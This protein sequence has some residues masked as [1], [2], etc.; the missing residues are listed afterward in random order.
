[1]AALVHKRRALVYGDSNTYGTDPAA[2]R[3]S[4]G[5]YGPEGRWPDILAKALAGEWE[6]VT[7]ALPGRCI[8]AMDFEWEDFAGA[9]ARCGRLDRFAVMLGTNDYLSMPRPDP[10]AVAERMERFL[11]RALAGPLAGVPA[12]V[13]APP[14]LDFGD[15]RYYGRYNTVSGV[16]SQ[17]LERCAARLGA[18][19]ADAGR[20]PLAP[21]GI[22]L[23]PQGHV[24]L[25]ERVLAAWRTGW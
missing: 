10:E 2:G 11:T 18:A 19:F 25:A 16:L 24:L 15:D 20:L 12:L 8:P 21:D 7:E 4:G 3:G 22:H 5:R 14:C 1:M 6:I 23:T 17:A 13:I 9:A